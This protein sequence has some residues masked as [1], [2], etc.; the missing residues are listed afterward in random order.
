M[1]D[2]PGALARVVADEATGLVHHRGEVALAGGTDAGTAGVT[3]WW[4]VL[5]PREAA[6]ATADPSGWLC[7]K[8]RALLDRISF[9]KRRGDWL[10][11]RL[12]AKQLLADMAGTRW[13]PPAGWRS[14]LIDHDPR[15]APVARVADEGPPVG[16]HLPGARLPIAL[17]CSHAGGYA[18]AAACWLADERSARAGKIAL[19]QLGADLEQVSPRSIAFV[20]DFLTPEERQWCDRSDGFERD[21]RITLAWSGKEAVLKALGCGLRVDTF[22]VTCLEE[23]GS[24]LPGEASRRATPLWIP[25][26]VSCRTGLLPPGAQTSVRWCRLRGFVAAL[27][28]VVRAEGRTVE[29]MPVHLSGPLGVQ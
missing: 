1:R 17:S 15:G 23:S 11:G 21:V 12:A 3:A 9:E 5:T 24:R 4:R 26:A 27:A 16:P 20:A 25:A 10:R 13:S 2:D 14:F 28:L 6:V 19:I 29:T 8:E 7:A 18:L 22:W